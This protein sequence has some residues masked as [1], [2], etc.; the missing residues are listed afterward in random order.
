[1]PG[2]RINRQQVEFYMNTRKENNTQALSALKAGIS[3]RS[4]RRIEKGQWQAN[5]KKRDWLTRPDPLSE[6]WVSECVPLLEN[7]P[8]LSGVILLEYLQDKYAGQYPD[9]LLRTIQRRIKTWR[10]LS[11]PEKPVIF[12]QSRSP[13]QQGISDFTQL[14]DIG[15]TVNGSVFKHLLYHFRLT[16]SGWSYMKVIQGGESFTAL[17]EGLQEALWRLGAAPQEHRTDSLSAAFRNTQRPQT[18]DATQNY[19]AL[20]AHYN[21]TPTRNNRG[22]GHENGAIESPHGHIKRRIKHSLALRGSQ[23][24]ESVAAYQ[25]WLETVVQ[26]HNQRN[27]K[28]LAVER[29]HLQ[30]LPRFKTC[31]FT[32]VMARVRS[33]STIDVC[34]VTYTVPSRLTGEYLRVHLYHDRLECFLGATHVIDLNR[35]YPCSKTQR[36]K[37]VD[38]R[39]VIHSLVKK[40]QAFRYS[41]LRD[42]LL[43]NEAYRQIWQH[44][45]RALCARSA[46]KFMVGLLH[47]AASHDCEQ[48]LSETVL[49]EIAQNKPLSLS[50]LKQRYCPVHTPVPEMVVEQHAL[51]EYDRLLAAQAAPEGRHA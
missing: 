34:R 16:F 27:A 45:D 2:K 11:G 13:G 23:D 44:V 46:C 14:K 41:Q 42:D 50:R 49:D 18:D 30:A 3:E 5:G 36:A 22:R 47:L 1:M 38:Y 26:Q 7:N 32:E 51:S 6:V 33:S 40:P 24:F 9:K 37:Q 21:L 29:P 17:A 19:T 48:R 10:A 35:I 15:I 20:C 25:H 8:D 31:D 39:H 4:G 12:R 28:A 43:P